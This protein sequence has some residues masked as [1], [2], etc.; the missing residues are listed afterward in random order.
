MGRVVS[1]QLTLTMETPS[2]TEKW[3]DDA[4]DASNDN[5]AKHIG[6][7]VADID[8]EENVQKEPA[9][10]VTSQTSS[11]QEL[12]ETTQK[13]DGD[14]QANSLFLLFQNPCGSI[15][16]LR[17]SFAKTST[18]KWIRRKYVPMTV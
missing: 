14:D 6:Q 2:K 3:S 8:G 5:S 18:K 16:I 9:S 1:I 13:N 11:D 10:V 7:Y 17:S 4:N 12:T 15:T